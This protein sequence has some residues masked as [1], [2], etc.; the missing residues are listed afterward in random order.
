MLNLP[1]ASADLIVSNLGLNNFDHPEAAL[2][3]CFR[4]AKPGASLLLTTNLVGHMS[5]FY[6]AYRNVLLELGFSD[7]IAA[8]ERRLNAI[9][10]ERGELSLSVPAA[11]IEARK[12]TTE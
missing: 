4:I 11:C 2:R 3:S 9:A 12:P 5:D 7:R 6:D 8:L 10:A 1:D